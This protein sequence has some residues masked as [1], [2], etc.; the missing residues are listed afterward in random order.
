MPEVSTSALVQVAATGGDQSAAQMAKAAAGV[1]AVGNA[2]EKTGNQVKKSGEGAAGSVRGFRDFRGALSLVVPQSGMV[3]EGLKDLKEGSEFLSATVAK[4]LG[5]ALGALAGPIGVAVVATMAIVAGAFLANKAA[6]EEMEKATAKNI[7]GHGDLIK[8]FEA[9]QKSGVKLTATQ[10]DYLATLKNQYAHERMLT[11]QQLQSAIARKN[12]EAALGSYMTQVKLY[13]ASALGMHNIEAKL[14]EDKRL[15]SVEVKRLQADLE[16]WMKTGKALTD[17]LT[18]EGKAVDITKDKVKEY[19]KAV[20]TA[21]AELAA[22]SEH[23]AREREEVTEWAKEQYEA[24]D[25]A[26]AGHEAY[27]ALRTATATR[28]RVVDK[29]QAEDFR[30][31]WT[32]ALQGVTDATSKLGAALIDSLARGTGKAGQA[33]T[34]FRDSMVTMVE[35]MIAK[36]LVLGAV[37]AL[38][39]GGFMSGGLQ[40]IGLG[41]VTGRQFGGEV[42]GPEGAPTLLMAHG[43]ERVDRPTAPGASGGGTQVFNFKGGVG[44]LNPADQR[45]IGRQ[46]RSI[47]RSSGELGL[48]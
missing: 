29:K 17:S 18:E 14:I 15:A 26:K 44:G 2:A 4:K 47:I 24:L 34:A 10:R 36:F 12:Q 7:K 13:W 32:Q 25:K 45:L 48:V 8:N 9:L 1:A 39:G 5:P 46:M 40:A 20:R 31:N 35:E 6:A 38:T 19:A 11:I 30:K 21:S 37:S 43:G 27:A 3:L 22:P 41:G 42:P 28:L 33:F 23:W 16:S